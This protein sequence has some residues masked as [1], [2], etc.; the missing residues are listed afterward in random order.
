MARSSHSVVKRRT[1][2]KKKQ[3]NSDEVYADLLYTN[4]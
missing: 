4:C 2:K 1:S 3:D